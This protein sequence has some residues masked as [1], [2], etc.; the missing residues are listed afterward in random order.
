MNN[1]PSYIIINLDGVRLNIR[2]RSLLP[3]VPKMPGSW[4]LAECT[5]PIHSRLSCIQNSNPVTALSH[6]PH[7]PGL[8]ERRRRR[9]STKWR[10]G[11]AKRRRGRTKRMKTRRRT[12]T[13]E[14]SLLF[15]HEW[16]KVR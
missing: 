1:E 12:R 15:L 9:R 14:T 11:R 16:Q 4:C 8:T 13:I 6:E 10:G 3:L 2:L 5:S 7:C